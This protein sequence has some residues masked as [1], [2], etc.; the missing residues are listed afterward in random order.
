M[1]PGKQEL[2]YV[3][4]LL[5]QNPLPVRDPKG[6]V[7]IKKAGNKEIKLTS[8]V[9]IPF[10]HL[11]RMTLALAIT[12]SIRNNSNR[13]ELGTVT[14]W[15]ARMEQD[16][17]GG[18]TGSITR[19]QEQFNRLGN[20]MISLTQ[21]DAS[22]EGTRQRQFNMLVAE[23]LDLYWG[24]NKNL[25]DLPTL[26]DNYIQFSNRF[27]E[28]I[29]NH[30]VPIDLVVYD[31]FQAPLAQDIYAWLSW[32]MGALEKPLTLRWGV[33]ETQF[34][35]KPSRNQSQWRKRWLEAA[36]EVKDAGYPDAKIIG[37]PEGITLHPS[38]RIIKPREPGHLV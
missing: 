3:P 25:A 22:A 4:S 10:G 26:F 35:D 24:K 13:V 20:T 11:G 30:A 14:G 34:S 16:A 15:L 28:Y 36:L 32:K 6:T 8:S 9:G 12:D 23:E 1:I 21:T 7:F 38:P 27:F 37:S 29:T 17:T 5:V 19:V 18:K 2:G 33:V 31:Q